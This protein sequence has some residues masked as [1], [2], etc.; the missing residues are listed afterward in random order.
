VKH[1]KWF[2]T[3]ALTGAALAAHEAYAFVRKYG[4]RHG[5]RS[6]WGENR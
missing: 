1:L 5:P 6:K 3:A 2:A 4:L